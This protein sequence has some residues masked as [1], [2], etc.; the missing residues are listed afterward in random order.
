[1][2]AQATHKESLLEP[3]E[4]EPPDILDLELEYTPEESLGTMEPEY[5]SECTSEVPQDT[6]EQKH[7]S[8]PQDRLELECTTEESLDRLEP[9]CTTEESQII[10]LDAAELPRPPEPPESLLC[11]GGGRLEDFEAQDKALEEEFKQAV[12]ARDT[13]SMLSVVSRVRA[14]RLRTA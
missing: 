2:A 10:P 4:E 12:L 13:A 1:M 7:T 3:E 14:M 9:E 8:E 6:L 11:S 5:T